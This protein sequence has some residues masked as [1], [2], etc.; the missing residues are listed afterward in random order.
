MRRLVS[1]LV[2][3]AFAL[4]AAAQDFASKFM[5][6]C[7]GDT[8]V[9]CITV[10][11]KMMEQ[12]TR[13]ADASHK[14]HIAQAIEKLKS[15]RIVSTSHHSLSYYKKAKGILMRNQQRFR[16]DKSYRK[17]NVYGDFFLRKNTAGNTVELVML[18]ADT[19]AHKLVIVNLTGDIDQ[20]FIYSLMKTFGGRT[21]RA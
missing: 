5:E 14:E 1:L 6:S 12:L 2:I 9:H 16:H 13:H 20:E 7:D 17:D 3:A 4:V 10:S 18:H 19:K 8:A 15:A 11:P 21:A